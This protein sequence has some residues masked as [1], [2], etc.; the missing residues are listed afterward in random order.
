MV[1]ALNID[2]AISKTLKGLNIELLKKAK[3]Q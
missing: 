2:L 1:N 3:K